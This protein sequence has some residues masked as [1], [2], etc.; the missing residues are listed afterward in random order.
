MSG[1]G[2]VGIVF[3]ISSHLK[4]YLPWVIEG[5]HLCS[6][7]NTL[8]VQPR[9]Y[10]CAQEI[11]LSP[12]FTAVHTLQTDSFNVHSGTGETKILTSD[13]NQRRFKASQHSSYDLVKL[14]A[15]LTADFNGDLQSYRLWSLLYLLYCVIW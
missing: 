11:K 3:G 8:I 12:V 10:L 15:N 13:G 7:S 2:R 4:V 6:C 14:F 1:L 9:H 5:R